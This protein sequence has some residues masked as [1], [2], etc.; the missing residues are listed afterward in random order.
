MQIETSMLGMLRR[1]ISMISWHEFGYRNLSKMRKPTP[2]LVSHSALS[3]EESGMPP[4]KGL[5]SSSLMLLSPLL[6]TRLFVCGVSD[7]SYGFRP[8]ALPFFWREGRPELVSL[9]R[10][11]ED[12]SVWVESELSFEVDLL[13]DGDL[14][15]LGSRPLSWLCGRVSVKGRRSRAPD[16]LDLV[17]S[18]VRGCY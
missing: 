15:G 2:S 10:D 11:C 6:G 9:V 18:K 3:P 8:V 4:G 17:C 16:P 5:R 14:R 13:F 7:L 12:A 1:P